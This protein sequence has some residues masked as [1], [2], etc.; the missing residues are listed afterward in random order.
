MS[1]IEPPSLPCEARLA[2]FLTDVTI[3]MTPCFPYAATLWLRTLRI[4]RSVR[5]GM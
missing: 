4:I 5:D 2:V 1:Y 3:D